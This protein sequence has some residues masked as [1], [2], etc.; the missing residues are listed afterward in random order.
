MKKSLLLA[1]ATAGV[2]LFTAGAA[3]AH[4]DHRSCD[5][6]RYG[7]HRHAGKYAQQRVAC[8]RPRRHNDDGY[9][10]GHGRNN[11][12]NTCVTKCT[13]FGP[14]KQCKTRCN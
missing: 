14:F 11:H 12:N 10:R 8:E 2:A 9:G 1:V 4:G 13:G 3:M 5:D 6:G 7:W